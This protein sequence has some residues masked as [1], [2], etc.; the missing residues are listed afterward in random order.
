VSEGELAQR[1]ITLLLRRW[2]EGDREALEELSRLLHPELRRI[3]AAH[4][5]G[6]R[7]DHTLE[8]TAVVHE[9]YARIHDLDLTWHDR[10]HFL[11]M[12]S[13]VMRRV[14]VDH[15]RAVRAAKRGGCIATVPLAEAPQSS[16]PAPD[17]LDLDRAL[18]ELRSHQE[19][20]SQ[21]VELHYF[22][23][24]TYREIAA[25]LGISQVTVERDLRFAKVW[26][27]KRLEPRERARAP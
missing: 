27:R 19:R 21:V 8:P 11:S 22:G 1:P 18:E 5:R 13:R 6:E 9:A 2:R 23:G 12:A 20:P 3:A 4:M 10:V 24:L 14:L 17:F 15:A 26:L 25:A 16:D 7:V